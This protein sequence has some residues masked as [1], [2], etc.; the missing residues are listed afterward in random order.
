MEVDGV[1]VG[2]PGGGADGRLR[3]WVGP[4]VNRADA[5]NVALLQVELP[6]GDTVKALAVNIGGVGDKTTLSLR[7]EAIV[8]DP[9][10]GDNCDDVYTATIQENIY[11]GDHVR[12][13]VSACGNDDFVIKVP[14]G[15]GGR[16]MDPG[17]EIKIGWR[18]QDCRALDAA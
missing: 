9:T 8:L 6:S 13:R 16:T 17:Q 14:R 5:L 1:A 10:D 2:G 12:V 4:G 11:M 3:R 7:P 15:A 18:S